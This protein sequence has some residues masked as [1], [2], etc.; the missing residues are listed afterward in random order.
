MSKSTKLAVVFGVLAMAATARADLGFYANCSSPDG[1]PVCI[2]SR[3]GDPNGK[4]IV[5]DN[6]FVCKQV[7]GECRDHNLS[8][9][10]ASTLRDRTPV[11]RMECAAADGTFWVLL[12]QMMNPETVFACTGD[13]VRISRS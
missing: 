3:R 10:A 1:Q 6:A 12:L 7:G 2:D 8:L 11:V 4:L 5:V 13:T 9:Q